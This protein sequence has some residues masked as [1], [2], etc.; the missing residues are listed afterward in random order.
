M[1]GVGAFPICML[2]NVFQQM[3]SAAVLFVPE[4]MQ[5]I[6]LDYLSSATAK[7]NLSCLPD[8]EALLCLSLVA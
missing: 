5:S 6:H 8:R 2:I 4:V 1:G 7:H 3:K